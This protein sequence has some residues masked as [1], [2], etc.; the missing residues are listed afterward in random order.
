M[1]WS[2]MD[3]WLTGSM[4]QLAGLRPMFGQYLH[5]SSGHFFQLLVKRIPV[6][7]VTAPT[8]R[9]KNHEKPHQRSIHFSIEKT[10]SEVSALR[11][12]QLTH[13]CHDFES[14]TAV[15]PN[16]LAVSSKR[17]NGKKNMEV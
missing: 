2:G 7:P 9:P 4:D 8:L 16:C 13:R 1:E 5:D 6:E 14:G 11:V 15:F 3:Q 12:L 10:Q 17:G